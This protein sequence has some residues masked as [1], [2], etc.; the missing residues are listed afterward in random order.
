[1]KIFIS[2]RRAE[3]SKTWIVG[4]IHEKLAEAFGSQNVFRDIYNIAG[5]DHWKSVLEQEINKS[6]VMLVIIGSDWASIAHPDGKKRL[7]D[8]EDVTRW[9]VA[10]GIERSHKGETRVIPVLVLGAE[11]PGREDLPEN[12][13][14]LPDMNAVRLR[15]YPDFN[16]D[17][18][19][20]IRAIERV[21]DFVDEE[22]STAYYVPKTVFVPEGEFWMGSPAGDEIPEYETPQHKISIPAYHIGVFPVTNAQYEVFINRHKQKLVTPSMSWDGQKVPSGKEN[23]PVIGV[24]WYDTKEYCEWLTEETGYSFTLPNE[25]QWEKACRGGG[26]GVYPWGDEFDPRRCNHGRPAPAPVNAYP[27]QSKF[28]FDYVGNIRQWTC[29]LWGENRFTP[30]ESYAYNKWRDG[31]G[32]NNL[33]VGA[34]IRR[35]MR[36]SIPQ[37]SIKMLRCSARS[38]QLP[39]ET[40]LSSAL[41]GFR[42]VRS[43]HPLK[44][45]MEVR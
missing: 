40:G 17:L 15:N 14:E 20:L 6:H 13:G 42:V 25:A 4:A 9:E 34:H 35:V 31:D 43:T 44:S 8:E 41:F 2:Y 36:G 38:G 45:S 32:R 22:I 33:E 23:H 29:T 24:S 27:A 30:D 21:R 1:M 3:D 10:S 28:G 18:E 19:S 7:F 11:M 16:K 39:K 37:D 12:L 5:G 26:R